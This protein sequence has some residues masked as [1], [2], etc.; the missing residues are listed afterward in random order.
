MK[1]DF[2]GILFLG[3]S[4]VLGFLT[5]GL[6]HRRRKKTAK[7][8]D[9]FGKIPEPYYGN[10]KVICGVRLGR[11]V[12]ALEDSPR[13]LNRREAE[14]YCVQETI[15]G[16]QCSFPQIGLEEQT[17]PVFDVLNA[18]LVKCGGE[19]LKEVKYG[20]YH[21]SDGYSNRAWIVG[22]DN[23]SSDYYEDKEVAF[24]RPVIYL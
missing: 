22:F 13:K 18:C 16:Q 12:F 3:G 23:N 11:V 15:N 2:F 24:V 19:A 5:A 7:G 1:K 21:A 14:L 10:G 20:G 4:F 9:C 8:A 6:Y 17:A